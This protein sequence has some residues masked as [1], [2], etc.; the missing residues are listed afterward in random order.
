MSAVASELPPVATTSPKFFSNKRGV[1]IY[2]LLCDSYMPTN[3]FDRAQTRDSP[4]LGGEPTRDPQKLLGCG[5]NCC[6]SVRSSEDHWKQ[7]APKMFCRQ[8]PRCS[9]ALTHCDF[10]HFLTRAKRTS[11]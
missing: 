9:S 2:W 1:P 7:F 11:D 8:E 3:R 4:A 5:Q 6:E 10:T